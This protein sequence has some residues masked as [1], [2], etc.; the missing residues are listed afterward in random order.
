[1]CSLEA[2]PCGVF[3][4]KQARSGHHVKLSTGPR[5]CMA[6][7][8]PVRER[9]Q[10]YV[11]LP[12]GASQSPPLFVELTG[13]ARNRRSAIG[14][15]R[16]STFLWNRI[17]QA[18]TSRLDLASGSFQGPDGV[19]VFTDASGADGSFQQRWPRGLLLA[20][21]LPKWRP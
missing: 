15:V 3:L 2:L 4:D 14:G 20:G 11:V 17:R 21:P 8:H 19:T 6:F 12:F 13:P 1:M 18:A 10:R 7:H 9:L 5:R 16:C